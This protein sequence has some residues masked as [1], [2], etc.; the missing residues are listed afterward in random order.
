VNT[1][2]DLRTATEHVAANPGWL[3]AS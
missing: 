3:A 1:P 2:K